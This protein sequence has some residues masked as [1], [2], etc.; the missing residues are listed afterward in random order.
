M[1]KVRTLGM[2]DIAKINPTLT[3]NTDVENYTF[4]TKVGVTYLIMNTGYGDQADVEGLVIKAGDFLN[5]YNLRPWEDQELVIDQKHITFAS[6]QTY[7]NITAGTTL[8]TIG[9]D[10]KLA[11]A[12]SV[13]A[14]G[15]FFKVTAKT[16]LTEKAVIAKVMIAA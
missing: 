12:D 7:N 4:L 6:G 11:I 15:V 2:Y 16:N 3:N 10:G 13:P 8:L 1:I 5:G 14:E 9:N